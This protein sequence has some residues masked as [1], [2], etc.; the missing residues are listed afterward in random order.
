MTRQGI[1]FDIRMHVRR[2]RKAEWSVICL[3]PRIGEGR[4]IT[5]NVT[6]GGSVAPLKAF[7]EAQFGE[8]KG[9]E[10][11]KQL[12][13]LAAEMPEHFQA[14]YSD[15]VLDALGID[16]GLDPARRPWLFEIN[17]FPWSS[18]LDLEAAIVKVGYA[19]HLAKISRSVEQN[20]MLEETT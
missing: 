16:I 1:P 14:L 17:P 4:S 5:S 11:R 8:V 12:L 18:F 20:E 19:I 7:L 9:R 10:I 6:A 13:N 15:R 2:N 3:Y